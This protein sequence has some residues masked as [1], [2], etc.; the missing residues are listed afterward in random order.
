MKGLHIVET[1]T[2]TPKIAR[3]VYPE[4]LSG[5]CLGSQ[6]SVVINAV[7]MVAEQMWWSTTA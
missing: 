3:S 2:S 4:F 5:R 6:E 7:V 1:A